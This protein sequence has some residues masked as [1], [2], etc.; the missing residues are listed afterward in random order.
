L[1]GREKCVF[2]SAVALVAAVSSVANAGK[3]DALQV[4][5]KWSKAF[6]ASDVDGITN[7]YAPDALFLGTGSKT[8]VTKTEGIHVF[9]STRTASRGSVS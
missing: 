7:L 9:T 3:E 8:V 5:E 1:K 2:L 4:V 6:N